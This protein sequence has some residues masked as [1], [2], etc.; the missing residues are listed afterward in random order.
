MD[1]IPSPIEIELTKVKEYL[2]SIGLSDGTR[3]MYC[4][5]L[6]CIGSPITFDMSDEE[7]LKIFK[8]KI[9]T[10]PTKCA[11]QAYIRFLRSKATRIDDIR[12]IAFV[13]S[14]IKAMKIGR[15]SEDVDPTEILSP[16]EISKLFNAVPDTNEDREF[17]LLLPLSYESACRAN[18]LLMN[19][20]CNVNFD[21]KKITITKEL[22]KSGEMRY[23]EFNKSAPLFLEYYSLR[24]DDK[25][26]QLSDRIFTMNYQQYYYR[27]K[28]LGFD[29]LGRAIHPHLFRHSLATNTLIEQLDKG[30]TEADVLEDL[31]RYLGHTSMDTTKIYINIARK[32]RDDG[33]ISKYGSSLEL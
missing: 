4:S 2:K 29:V 24:K 3:N 30:R 23:V 32:I 8:T 9:R 15:E 7:I 21:L 13:E 26:F 10:K 16:Q 14:E 12:K 19:C 22:S 31:R 18:E 27:L 6:A 20:W 28:K 33:I 1:K 25:K 5:Y 17:K 11:F